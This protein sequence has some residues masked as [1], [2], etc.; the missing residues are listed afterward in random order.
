MTKKRYFKKPYKIRKK[1]SI[2]SYRF[3]WLGLLA[4]IIKGGF[5][6]LIFFSV[7]FQITEIE[8]KGNIKIYEQTV[9]ELIQ[10][11]IEQQI[12]FWDTK[13]IFL[14]NLKEINKTLLIKFPLIEEVEVKKNFP[15]V[16]IVKI[17][18]RKPVAV[19]YQ[20]GQKFFI[21]KHGVIFYSIN[22]PHQYLEIE[23]LLLTE[24]LKLGK[25]ILD[26]K[27]IEQ[28]L[29]IEQQTKKI[30]VFFKKT[31]IVSDERLNV[32]TLE[33]WEIY[34]NLK[35]DILRQTFHLNLILDEKI[36]LEKR[37]N[38]EYID[39]RFSPRVFFRYRD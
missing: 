30:D 39:L 2:F 12:G 33:N 38:L 37:K 3:F 34:F 9:Q 36:P 10:L 22:E 18:E 14:V 32:K 24:E 6:Y 25:K 13:S 4:I 28:I 26:K 7:W 21:D 20:Q 29:E 27:L 17:K 23:S 16:L 35:D 15:D 8:I 11:Q 31:L 19:F 1:K 5:F